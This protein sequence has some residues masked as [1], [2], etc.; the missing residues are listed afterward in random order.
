MSAHDKFIWA[1]I[2]LAILLNLLAMIN[3]R[4]R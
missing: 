1:M 4:E 3:R 2:T